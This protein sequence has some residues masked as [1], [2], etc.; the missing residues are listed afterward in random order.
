MLCFHA[1]LHYPSA[2]SEEDHPSEND[3]RVD[4]PSVFAVG[5]LLGEVGIFRVE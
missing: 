2:F 1:S 4:P 5:N 3:H